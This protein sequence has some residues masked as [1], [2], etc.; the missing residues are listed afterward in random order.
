MKPAHEGKGKYIALGVIVIILAVLAYIFFFRNKTHEE[1][2]PVPAEQTTPAPIVKDP[3]DKQINETA[4]L[5]D[6]S[7]HYPEF[8]I[9]AVDAEIMKYVTTGQEEFKKAFTP[10]DDTLRDAF[11]EGAKGSLTITFEIRKSKGITTVVF[12][13]SE[14]TGGAHPN[15]FINTIHISD[16]GK[17]LDLNDMFTVSPEVYLETLSK[18]AT[19]QLKKD[20]GDGFFEEGATSNPENWN[21]WYIEDGKL[22]ILFT[23]YQV[24]AYAN[25]EPELL[26]PLSELKAIINPL[27]I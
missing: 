8:G 13:G 14:Y 19:E 11:P 7:I 22:V 10:I 21:Q 9:P 25:G 23:V 1:I 5:Y 26:V 16:D 3:A 18:R 24:T 2:G 4:E 15:P 17:L 27:F 12:R 20:Y 6:I